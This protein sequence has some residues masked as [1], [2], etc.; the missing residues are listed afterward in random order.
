MKKLY[1]LLTAVLLGVASMAAAQWT[2]PF[3]GKQV[4]IK[5]EAAAKLQA[6]MAMPLDDK[7]ATDDSRQ[8][9]SRSWYEKGSD[10]Y[11]F[12]MFLDTEQRWCD[13]LA[14]RD[15]DDVEHTYTFEEFPFYLVWF[16]LN[17]VSFSNFNTLGRYQECAFIPQF[18]FWPCYYYWQQVVDAHFNEDLVTDE[19][20]DAVL[21]MDL[22]NNSK[23]CR[24]FLEMPMK[25]GGLVVGPEKNADETNWDH[26]V[27]ANQDYMQTVA[28]NG[29]AI[30][31]YTDKMV[32][33]T[34]YFNGNNGSSVEFK[35][36][37]DN[38]ELEMRYV[39]YLKLNTEGG[40]QRTAC[41]LTDY[42]G[43]TKIDSFEKKTVDYPISELH[44][45]LDG[46]TGTDYMPSLADPYI[47]P[48]GPVKRYYMQGTGSEHVHLDYAQDDVKE[49]DQDKIYFVFDYNDPQDLSYFF[50]ALYSE[51]SSEK[52]YGKWQIEKTTYS[53]DKEY[54]MIM[55]DMVPK[56]GS[57]IPCYV[58]MPRDIVEYAEK[59]NKLLP[60]DKF[61]AYDGFNAMKASLPFYLMQG[62]WIAN[63]TTDGFRFSGTD[64][65]GN[66]VVASFK[67][68]FYYHGD[69]KNMREY[70]LLPTV[71]T[72]SDV[73]EAVA[74]AEVAI[75]VANG[76]VNVNTPAACRVNIYDLNGKAVYAGVAY[77]DAALSVELPG[78][79]Y[80]VKAG[81]TAKKVVL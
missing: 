50:G 74:E 77:P 9:I 36:L 8:V 44:I 39:A 11:Y 81:N 37:T 38:K 72:L 61:R 41:R 47:R 22:C 53:L 58:D 49:F 27:I 13:M 14:W 62:S 33:G 19:N 60:D 73:A 80:V 16:Q 59:H 70:E 79:F 43:E 7:L 35:S 75:T 32:D 18:T 78:G 17:G 30:I 3:E 52:P 48:W 21:P 24:K 45:F 76:K 63:G 40:F 46:V 54:D 2:N 42:K 34:T 64:Q 69:P 55:L 4:Y 29:D 56:A 23:Y 20:L 15:K 65:Y 10:R 67:G 66:E 68:D 25:D 6:K 51:D 28:T 57:A 31:Y 1:M 5:P 12:T 71:G 26:W